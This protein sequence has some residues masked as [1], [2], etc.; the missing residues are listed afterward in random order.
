MNNFKRPVQQPPQKPSNLNNFNT[1]KPSFLELKSRIISFIRQNGPVLP[2]QVAKAFGKDTMFAGAMLSELIANK[3][4]RVSFAKVGGSPVY[5]M[6]EQ[7]AKLEIL[8]EHLSQKPKQAY[9]LLKEKQVVR[10]NECEPWERVALRELKDFAF[11]V[12]V[13]H[14]DGNEEIFWRWHLISEDD[15]RKQIT[16]I[17]S[18]IVEQIKPAATAPDDVGPKPEP[19]K[20]EKPDVEDPRKK[21]QKE[22]LPKAEKLPKEKKP[23]K[24]KVDAYKNELLSF[25]Q[26]KGLEVLEEVPM[27]KNDYGFVVNLESNVGKLS[28]MAIAKKKKK[29]SD[30]DVL[31][32]YSSA[33]HHKLPLII[34]AKELSKKASVLLEKDARGVVFIQL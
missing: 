27:K 24:A 12:A 8:R 1:P 13:R 33:Q 28:Y 20:P 23:K 29:L 25:L 15:A 11:P 6:P 5:Y 16:G 9:D 4:L 3:V 32:A 26:Q 34:I 2:I 31:L 22:K 17:V 14:D 18:G 10:D 21:M 19:I 7:E 30:D